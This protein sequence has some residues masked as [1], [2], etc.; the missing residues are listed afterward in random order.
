MCFQG[1]KIMFP[2]I[3][4]CKL[5]SEC[6]YI[7]TNTVDIC[8]MVSYTGVCVC[9]ACVIEQVRATSPN[10]VYTTPRRGQ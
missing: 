3:L 2:V 6:L 10:G 8:V 9:D 5:N 1:I 7:I 4:L